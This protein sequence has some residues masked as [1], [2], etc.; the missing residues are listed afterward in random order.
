MDVPGCLGGMEDPSKTDF[1]ITASDAQV[2]GTDSPVA[3]P[4]VSLSAETDEPIAPSTSPVTAPTTAIPPVSLTFEPTEESTVLPTFTPQP[5]IID[6]PVGLNSS[7]LFP[8]IVIVGRNG[9]PLESYP[10]GPCQGDCDS[11]DDCQPGLVCYFREANGAVPGCI[12]GDGDSS[13]SDYCITDPSIPTTGA[14]T[15][16]PSD[17][18]VTIVPTITQPT[19]SPTTSSLPTAFLSDYPS[20][21]PSG[22]PSAVPTISSMPT[23]SVEPTG[24]PTGAPTAGER[25]GVRL[26]LYWEEGYNW[27]D[28]LV[29]RKC[30]SPLIPKRLM[31][32]LCAYNNTA[33]FVSGCMI[34]NYRGFPGTGKCWYGL[35]T[36]DCREDMVYIARCDS[37]SRQMF[38]IYPLPGGTQYQVGVYKENLCMERLELSII[39]QPC[40]SLNA[41]QRFWLP[42]GSIGSKRFELSP[43]TLD[44]HCVSQAHHPKS[45]EVMEFQ[46]CSQARNELI[47]T[48]FWQVY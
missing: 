4:V 15:L 30:K 13:R 7:A 10:M 32:R 31:F 35:E 27:Q 2:I 42:R 40:D 23:S 46:K 37:D 5:V 44:N 19:L 28:E 3:A 14:I 48:S 1:C 20:S 24:A 38:S 47:L 41:L 36:L 26:K 25:Q 45:G 8:E 21:V 18:P 16:T 22:G 12:G 33:S 29:E 34:H 17:A 11:D 6:D 39:L 43:I 9:E